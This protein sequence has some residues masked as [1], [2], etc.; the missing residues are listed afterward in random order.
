MIRPFSN[1][2]EYRHWLSKNCNI[3]FKRYK[4]DRDPPTMCDIEEAL[5][6]AYVTDGKIAEKIYERMKL[7]GEFNYNCPEII[8]EG[9]LNE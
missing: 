3:C 4:I 9:V 8:I 2:S 1:G 7:A 5:A 6:L